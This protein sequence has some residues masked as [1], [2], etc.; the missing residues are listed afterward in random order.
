MSTKVFILLFVAFAILTAV[1][2]AM[3]TPGGARFVRDILAGLR[4]GL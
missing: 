4:G 1:V 2:V 3:H